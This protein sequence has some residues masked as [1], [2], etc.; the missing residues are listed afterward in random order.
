MPPP[1]PFPLPPPAS[2]PLNVPQSL[3][4]ALALHEQGRLD[5]AG[6]LYAAILAVRPD[7]FDALQM[8]GVVKLAKGEPAEALRL[9]SQAMRART[10]SPPAATSTSSAPRPS[11]WPRSPSTPAAGPR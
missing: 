2:V 10:P 11:S 1:F 4:K 3:A 6:R 9:V 8:L 7:H 5:E